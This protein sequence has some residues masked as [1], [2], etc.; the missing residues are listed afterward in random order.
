MEISTAMCKK[1]RKLQQAIDEAKAFCEE[2]RDTIHQ[3][4]ELLTAARQLNGDFQNHQ[5]INAVCL[6]I[7]WFYNLRVFTKR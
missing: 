6:S 2:R 4:G 1:I 7:F 3:I 5:L